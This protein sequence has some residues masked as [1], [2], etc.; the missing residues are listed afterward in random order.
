MR[1]NPPTLFWIVLAAIMAVDRFLPIVSFTSPWLPW[2]GGGLLVLGLAVSIAGKRQFR[3][4]GTNVY[5]FEAPGQLVTDGLYRISRNPM[6]L[7]LVLAGTGA[8]LISGTLSALVL[9]ATFGLTVRCWYIA[10]EESA[11]RRQF[12]ESYEAYCRRVGRWFGR[13]RGGIPDHG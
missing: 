9:A 5:T 13:Q 7:G 10:F 8:A 1:V 2:C 11:M 6:Y 12:G 3:R 4:V